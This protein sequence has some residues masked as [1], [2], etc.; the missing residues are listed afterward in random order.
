MRDDLAKHSKFLSYVLR[1]KPDAVGIVLDEEGWADI[2]ALIAAA[3]THGE[4]LTRELIQ[5]IVDENDKKRFAISADGRRIRAVQGHSVS[6]DLKLTPQ[7]PPAQLFHGTATRF[8]Q[9]IRAEGLHSSNRQHVHLSPDEKTAVHVG[10][11]HG[12]PVVLIVN[13]GAMHAAGHVFYFSANGVW[14]TEAV[15]AQFITFPQ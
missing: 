2:D 6:V 7:T 1:H 3:A 5:Q 12:K 4:P 11:R 8:V 14:L 9:S 13:S 15:P 10:S